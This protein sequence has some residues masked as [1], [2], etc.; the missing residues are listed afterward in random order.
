M[1]LTLYRDPPLAREN[2]TLPAAIYNLAHTLLAHSPHGAVFVPIRSMQ[3]LAVI[4]REE[5]VF[6][7]SQ[8]KHQVV[9]AWQHFRPQARGALDEPVP[10]EVCFHRPD[11]AALMARLQ[12]E[13]GLALRLLD[14]REK[15]D[16]PGRVL[17]FAPPPS[18]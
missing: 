3:Y 14:A 16:G 9:L 1:E 7:D 15:R 10:Y 6:V 2:R 8:H 12:A 18:R 17:H 11:G 13:L 4:D 5:F